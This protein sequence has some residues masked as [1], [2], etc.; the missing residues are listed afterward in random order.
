L[1]PTRIKKKKKTKD[2]GGKGSKNPPPPP[3]T[4]INNPF[5]GGGG[6]D[7]RRFSRGRGEGGEREKPR[8]FWKTAPGSRIRKREKRRKARR[9]EGESFNVWGENRKGLPPSKVLKGG[10]AGCGFGKGKGGHLVQ[11]KPLLIEIHGEEK[12]EEK[13]NRCD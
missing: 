1:N 6:K 7:R 2:G 12:K 8:N 9:T 4:G 11:P 13:S 3:R 5:R 10:E